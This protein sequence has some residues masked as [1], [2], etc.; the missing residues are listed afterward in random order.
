[1]FKGVVHIFVTTRI[2]AIYFMVLYSLSVLSSS[3][4]M[5]FHVLCIDVFLIFSA[6]LA[7]FIF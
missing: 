1:M 6:V 5:Y 4:F 7:L 3:M 2:C